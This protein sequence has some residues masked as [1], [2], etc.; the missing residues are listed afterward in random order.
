MIMVHRGLG[1]FMSY[2]FFNIEYGE[3]ELN[4]EKKN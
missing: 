1:R 2:V 3:K 4:K